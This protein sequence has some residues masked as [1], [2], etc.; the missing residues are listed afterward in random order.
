MMIRD[1]LDVD[2]SIVAL[3]IDVRDLK[4]HLLENIR[5][6]AQVEASNYDKFVSQNGDSTTYKMLGTAD[7]ELHRTC[8]RREF[9]SYFIT[10]VDKN[11]QTKPRKTGYDWGKIPKDILE[12]EI[13]SMRP[14]S[15]FFRN[16]S[17]GGEIGF[18]GYSI[19]AHSDKETIDTDPLFKGFEMDPNQV[20]FDDLEVTE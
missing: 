15:Y 5:I 9:Q 19:W 6:G 13:E 12:L 4:L 2:S 17:L 16:Y 14:S 1:L 3:D 7:K 18:H 20:S 8:I 10:E 11:G